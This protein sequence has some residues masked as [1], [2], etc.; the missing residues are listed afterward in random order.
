MTIWIPVLLRRPWLL[1]AFI[2]QAV[3]AIVKRAMTFHAS[4]NLAVED[5]DPERIFFEQRAGWLI[6]TISTAGIDAATSSFVSLLDE[7]ELVNDPYSCAQRLAHI[8]YLARLLDPGNVPELLSKCAHRDA[9]TLSIA[10]EYKRANTWFNNH[11][12]NDYRGA[13]LYLSIFGSRA[14]CVDM[15]RFLKQVEFILDCHMST[16][17]MNSQGPILNEGSISYEILILRNLVDLAC[18]PIRTPLADRFREWIIKDGKRVALVYRK[19]NTWILPQIG[20]V[21]P[22]WTRQTAED[23]LDGYVFQHKTIYRQIWRNE[24]DRLDYS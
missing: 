13:L 18:C 11:L 17:F 9:A 3:A 24:L 20:D 22:D 12:L 1:F 10:P 16:L 7:S 15:S 6:D 14:E 21:T 5:G 23:F 2:S 8:A 19:E 4:T